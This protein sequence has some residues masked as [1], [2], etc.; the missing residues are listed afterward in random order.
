MTLHRGAIRTF[1]PVRRT[2]IA[3]CGAASVIAGS[4]ASTAHGEDATFSYT[5]LAYAGTNPLDFPFVTTA[6][7]GSALALASGPT[8]WL[9][10]S[11][12][13]W[14]N[15]IDG[16]DP[17]NCGTTAAAPT[18][19]VLLPRSRTI[20]VA[21]MCLAPTSSLGV[22]RSTDGGAH[23]NTDVQGQPHLAIPV[24]DG[25]FISGGDGGSVLAV[26]S[27][28]ADL[29]TLLFSR[30]QDGGQTFSA[31]TV[32]NRNLLDNCTPTAPGSDGCAV[33]NGTDEGPDAYTPVLADPTDPKR[34]YVL[35]WTITTQDVAGG[36]NVALPW[37]HASKAYV[38]RSDD[39]GA[40]WT[41]RQILDIGDS[42]ATDTQ[43]ENDIANWFPTGAV[44]PAGNVYFAVSRRGPATTQSH[45][46]LMSS[47]DHGD[48]WTA[49]R[50][51]DTGGRGATFA[52]QLVAIGRG[53][54]AVAFY[55][56]S[57]SDETDP[58]ASW[59][60]LLDTVD[61]ATRARPDVTQQLVRAAVW[62]GSLCPQGGTLGSSSCTDRGHMSVGL[63][64]T[65][66]GGLLLS[67]VNAG[68]PTPF[69]EVAS[70]ADR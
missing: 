24:T 7:D 10:S 60:V 15:G 35:W 26:A 22:Y 48:H 50:R 16:I 34:L 23:W 58:S 13:S 14:G 45:V 33:R 27:S 3:V 54:V 55:G 43:D 36:S 6:A 19:G 53:R 4:L 63:T 31:P 67:Y 66:A 30:S 12:R 25:G 49:S 64:T 70:A 41:S 47:S 40:T 57:A 56:S 65:P 51:I 69:M 42:P 1:A 32:I 17:E 18:S 61:H 59:D 21:E 38:A 39:G 28:N 2:L 9:S 11:G 5:R 62:H 20:V 46:L 8:A 29:T 52:P 44:D 68:G 37:E